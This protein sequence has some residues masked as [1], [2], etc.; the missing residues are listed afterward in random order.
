[1]LASQL[2]ALIVK[3]A[4]IE[5]EGVTCTVI[6]RDHSFIFSDPK[7]NNM[8]EKWVISDIDTEVPSTQQTFAYVLVS[9]KKGHRK[10]YL[11][12]DGTTKFAN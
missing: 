2:C 5:V 4:L 6:E 7:I 11:N 1:M 3:G 9:T 12:C 8:L 10:I